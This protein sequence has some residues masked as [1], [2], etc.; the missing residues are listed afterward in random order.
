MPS[1]QT[2]LSKSAIQ[3][4]EKLNMKE[5][6]GQFHL[7]KS[8]KPSQRYMTQAQLGEYESRDKWG[9]ERIFHK[10][11]LTQNQHGKHACI[12][13]HFL[14]RNEI[15]PISSTESITEFCTRYTQNKQNQNLLCKIQNGA[16]YFFTKQEII[17]ICSLEITHHN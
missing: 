11:I 13:Q 17:T 6:K 9:K 3:F 2:H 14:R 10:T 7:G 16:R 12:F 5:E 1:S 4:M 8:G 15:G